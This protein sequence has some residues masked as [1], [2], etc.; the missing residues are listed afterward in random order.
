MDNERSI[1]SESKRQ[2]TMETEH[3]LLPPLTQ[4]CF[5]GAGYVGGISATAMA[6]FA[7]DNTYYVVDINEKQISAW[8]SEF[9]PVEEPGFRRVLETKRDGTDLNCPNLQF[10]TNINQAIL[11]S[12]ML[13][14][15]V[16][17][18]QK[19][20]DHGAEESLDVSH[21]EECIRRI[22]RVATNNKTIVLKSTV[23]CGTADSI[24]AMLRRLAK[25]GVSFTVLSNPEFLAEGTAWSNVV[26]P[27][28]IIIGAS[29]D[30]DDFLAA[31]ALTEIY[32]HWV[33]RTS[34][35]LMSNKSAELTKFATNVLLAQRISSINA[36]SAICEKIGAD[37]DHVAEACGLDQRIGR[38][39]LKASLGFGGSCFKKDTLSLAGFSDQLGLR[40]IGSYWRSIDDIN[41]LQKARFSERVSEAMG[42][43]LVDKR[44]AI[45]GC[46]FKKGVGDMRC[47]SAIPLIIEL[48]SKGTHVI[49][50]DGKVDQ[51]TLM[52]ALSKDQNSD[53][54]RS[55]CNLEYRTSLYDACEKAN[56]IVI[57]NDLE[58]ISGSRNT[59]TKEVQAPSVEWQDILR[60]MSCPRLLFDGRNLVDGEELAT[61]GF[62]VYMIG[63][64]PTR[65]P[66]C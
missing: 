43:T 11:R 62:Q 26:H 48:L 27:D 6:E 5:I 21:V 12:S 39:M 32:L 66:A 29:Q 42:N 37:V 64:Q 9:L 3:N 20:G 49:V 17:T 52:M 60:H 63:K 61:L 8:N 65:M 23:P 57:A 50:Y 13:F 36:I 1:F 30:R 47:S 24:K 33:P 55:L 28:R 41:E 46:A 44:I 7:P 56:A 25:P 4:V 16:D 59:E 40:Q 34:I 2:P 19:L 51:N 58:E 53:M 10:S 18:P 54:L 22:A 45:L 35:K 15:T 31:E 14:I 38:Y